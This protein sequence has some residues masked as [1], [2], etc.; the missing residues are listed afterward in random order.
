MFSPRMHARDRR[1]EFWAMT[2]APHSATRKRS[3]IFATGWAGA[4]VLSTFR[5]E[6]GAE[7]VLLRIASAYEATSKRRITPPAFGPLS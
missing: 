6:P 4:R 3:Q 7:D 2:A 1:S 5:A